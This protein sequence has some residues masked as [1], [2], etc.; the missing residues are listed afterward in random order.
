MDDCLA[1]DEN[2]CV[3][4]HHV[5][6]KEETLNPKE[7]ETVSTDSQRMW[8]PESASLGGDGG[9]TPGHFPSGSGVFPLK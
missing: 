4:G 3:Y 8:T 5:P 9:S 6:A 7:V 1:P 2:S